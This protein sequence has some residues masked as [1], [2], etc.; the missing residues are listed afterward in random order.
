MFR[1]LSFKYFFLSAGDT[2]LSVMAGH[3]VFTVNLLPTVRIEIR[4]LHFKGFVVSLT[5]H[6]SII[7]VI[8]QLVFSQ[9]VHRTATYRV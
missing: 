2:D 6:L 5:V 8:N 9:P 4:C 3:S 1:I 7:P